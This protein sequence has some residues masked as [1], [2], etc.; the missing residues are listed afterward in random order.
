MGCGLHSNTQFFLEVP[1]VTGMYTHVES[2]MLSNCNCE[3][4]TT[5]RSVGGPLFTE[6]L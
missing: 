5:L 3:L 2:E 4:G 6:L 1:Q